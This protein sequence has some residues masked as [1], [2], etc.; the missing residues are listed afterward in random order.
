MATLCPTCHTENSETA[1][2]CSNCAAVLRTPETGPGS[3]SGT[4][5]RLDPPTRT[6]ESH[7]WDLPTGTL[8]A[9]R[10]RIIEQLG[11]GG[12]GR[13]Y[14]ALDT[15]ANEEVAIKLIRPDIA[16]DK[17]TLERFVNEIKLAHKIAH[18]NV[19]KMY[20]L[21]EDQG[22]HFIT[23]EYVPGEDLK[24]FIRRSRRLDIATTVA[25][26]K[27]V[28][29]GL[30]E[31]HDEGIVH[32]D[33]KPSNI[34]ID[35]EG[36]A[37]ILDFGIARAAGSQGVTAEG[38][39]IGTPEYMAPEQV[40]GK[41]ADRRA[42]IYAFGVIMFEM[43]TGRLPFAADTPF[44]VAFKQQSERPTPPEELNP[45]T[46]PQLSAIILRCLAKDR[47]TRYQTTED[48]CRDLSQ[49]EETLHTTPLPSPWVRPATRKTTLQAV[50]E[51]FPWRK[52]IIPVIAF[53]GIMAA[54]TVVTR[55]LPKAKGAVHTV[56][57]V[58][59]EN[60]TGEPS[61][62]YLRKAIPNLL[63]TSL[64]QSK[65]LD[66]VPWEK[67]SDLAGRRD[68][69]VAKAEDRDAWFDVCR[70]AGVDAVVMG[71]F[72]KAE[73]LFAT[74]AKVYDVQTKNMIKS[75]GSRGEGVGSILRNQI[76]AL[77][78]DI[79]SGVGLS[80]G[81][82]SKPISK[83][84]TSSMDAYQLFL[85]GQE[86]FDRYYFDDARI[87]FEKAVEMDP[88]FALAYYYLARIYNNL[89][90]APKA[91]A[92]LD[93]FKKL[94]QANPGRGKEGL[95]I[96]ALSAAVD[97]DREGYVK[98][99]DEI[100][101]ADPSDKRAHADLGSFYRLAKKLP[102]AVAEFGKALAID[103]N[104][105]YAQNLLAYSYEELGEKDKAI[106]TFGRYAASH[107][108]EANPVDSLGDLYFLTGDYA[109]ARAKYQ[110]AL[111]LKPDFPSA[112]KL[113][114]LY[115][116]DGDYDAALRWTD[117]MITRA[118]TDG[119]RADGHQWKGFYFSLT[120]RFNDALAEL[121]TAETLAKTSGNQMLADMV[122][123][124]AL[125]TAY[126]WGRL[127]L[128]MTYL[129]KRMALRAET[130]QGTENLNKVYRLLYT[131]LY[132]VRSGNVAA[133]RQ[134]LGDMTGLAATI[135]DPERQMNA[136]ASNQL[137]REI[138]L[139]EG[140]LAGALKVF[141]ARPAVEINLSMA[142]TV[143]GKNLPFVDDFAARVYLKL[144]E[145]DKALKEYEQLVS[146]EPRDR[147]GAL[148]HPFSRLRLAALCEARGNA[149][150]AAEQYK[151]LATIWKQ[152]DPTLPD[153][154][155]VRAKLAHLKVRTV[156][157][158]N[159]PSASPYTLPFIGSL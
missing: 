9:G 63:I 120:G 138:L 10:Y 54:G 8:F 79:A 111:A 112:W 86:D 49:V 140:D 48:V 159:D 70:Q 157:T 144:G 133:A 99:M 116:M 66:V 39:V 109:Q 131:G 129:E 76:D 67:L 122:L 136:M 19:G 65:Y 145:A 154:A 69:D 158:K 37:K 64:E 71:S 58:G 123:R 35:R 38:S 115:A 3:G 84:V 124:D 32:R 148:V 75:V 6:Y 146:S 62:D 31:A 36:N 12:M 22:L 125:W 91:A 29:S 23:M 100:V 82:A 103:P 11:R 18:R 87:S 56:A 132:D 106:E 153:V 78:A 147:N 119:M 139:A 128:F 113:A 83:V 114:Y 34:M 55:L 46:P 104:F 51:R 43:V 21:G 60:L 14:R 127:D 59:F 110:Q 13:V 85:K 149:E 61:Y 137:E 2:F 50:V 121:G 92:S 15:K 25:I 105:G 142:S 40:E 44:V 7:S 1:N 107:P 57:I 4:G 68:L 72:T 101:K 24:S 30:G 88:S 102:E 41:E 90:D 74:D 98:R 81:A 134:K 27:Q 117:D 126:D 118:Q 26:A 45:Q 97:N 52:A 141:A 20:H 16:E 156:R 42:D 80:A 5:P 96:A 155:A 94:T 28:C 89:A 95:W 152:A 150:K 151:K 77:S 47:E 143:Q 130:N 135:K 73:N 53:L 33:L 93:R 17:R 108:G